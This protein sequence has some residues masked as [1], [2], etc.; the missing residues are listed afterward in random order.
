MRK[1]RDAD[2]ILSSFWSITMIRYTQCHTTAVS[3]DEST[4]LDIA[5]E[6]EAPACLV[7]D[8]TKQYRTCDEKKERT[9]NR[10]Q[11]SMDIIYGMIH[12]R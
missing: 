1:I 9:K 10:Q 7:V 11:I 6:A 3:G 8:K 2:V 12:E 4:H 5:R